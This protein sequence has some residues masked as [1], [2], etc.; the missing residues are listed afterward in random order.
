MNAFF[1]WLTGG[2]KFESKNLISA[3]AP[4]GSHTS[5]MNCCSKCGKA[6]A[7]LVDMKSVLKADMQMYRERSNNNGRIAN[8]VG[9][10]E[11]ATTT[12]GGRQMRLIDADALP[13]SIEY[14]VDEAGFGASF[15]VVHKSDNDHAPTVDAAQVVRCKDCEYCSESESLYRPSYLRCDHP[16]MEYDTECL[17]MWVEV[18]ADG[19]CSYGKRRESQDA[20]T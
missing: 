7:Y 16:N 12:E 14:L 15:D 17:D 13:V 6:F 11:N 3:Q 18:E 20:G 10:A 19:F 8:G 2:H 9:I 5:F 1:C 4:D